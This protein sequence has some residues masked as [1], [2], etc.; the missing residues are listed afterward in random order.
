MRNEQELSEHPGA[1][2]IG[3]FPGQCPRRRH[4]RDD[5]TRPV[6]PARPAAE[7]VW[8]WTR[9]ARCTFADVHSEHG[10]LLLPP[11][12]AWHPAESLR[13]CVTTGRLATHFKKG[14][15]RAGLCV[16]SES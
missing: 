6:P 1:Q 5:H 7:G 14:S 15:D 3:P 4:H 2:V 16:D 11:G 13:D 12:P 9:P 8:S 10:P